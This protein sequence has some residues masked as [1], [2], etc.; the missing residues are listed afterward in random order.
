VSQGRVHL[1]PQV[2]MATNPMVL[3]LPKGPLAQRIQVDPAM[4]ASLL[5]YA[6]PALADVPIVRGTFSVDLDSCRIPLGDPRQSQVAGR[7]VMHTMEI[8][9]GPMLRELSVLLGREVP[10]KLRQESAIAFHMENG[11]VYHEGLEIQFP[12]LA[13]RTHGW[14]GLDETLDIVADMPVPPK[15]LAGNTLVSQTMRN[16]TI[17]LPLRGTLKKPKLDAGEVARLSGQFIRKAAGN[18]IESGLNQLLRPKK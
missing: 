4:C 1:A 5:K 3:S 13:I 8:T 18:V 9:S 2:Q 14:V 7:L 11:R 10:A 6:A 17:R 15:W 16:Q 12:D